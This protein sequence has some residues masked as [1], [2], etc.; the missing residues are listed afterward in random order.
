MPRARD[1][2]LKVADQLL[3]GRVCIASMMQSGSKMALAVAFRY[4]A[5]RLC[6]GPTGKSDTPI[7]EY[8][9]QQRALTPLLAT[10]VAL[11]LGLNYVKER[12]AAA[13]G[14]AA[15]QVVD[16][17]TQREVRH[18]SSEFE[19]V[20]GGGRHSSTAVVLLLRAWVWVYWSGRG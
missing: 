14:F 15:G 6:V 11:N 8:Q 3:S 1:R 17:D 12:W 18:C 5:S 7:L 10:T 2:F 13:S 9:L 19:W 16:A 4:A 20:T